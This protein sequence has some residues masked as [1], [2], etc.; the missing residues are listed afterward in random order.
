MVVAVPN[1]ARPCLGALK[2]ALF[3]MQ[4]S[5]IRPN[6]G[7]VRTARRWHSQGSLRMRR[8]FYATNGSGRAAA[9]P[10][11]RLRR[12]PAGARR[13]KSHPADLNVRRPGR[14]HIS[15]ISLPLIN[16]NTFLIHHF[17]TVTL[18]LSCLHRI[19]TG[20]SG[21]CAA[22]SPGKGSDVQNS[23]R[24]LARNRLSCLAYKTP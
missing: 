20:R 22:P 1:P 14:Q 3:A 15:A 21:R 19:R 18:R 17:P 6:C 23:S 8:G 24:L 11:N 9:E 10:A 2:G 7:T 13:S 12:R 16:V 4:N 5:T